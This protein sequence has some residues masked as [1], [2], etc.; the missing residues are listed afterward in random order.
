MS[1]A[2]GEQFAFVGKDFDLGKGLG[3]I[4]GR[5]IAFGN[6]PKAR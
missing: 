6:T 5:N 1:A 3:A 2:V 4:S